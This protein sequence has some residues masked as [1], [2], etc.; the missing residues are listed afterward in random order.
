MNLSALPDVMFCDTDT[1]KIETAVIVTHEELTGKKLYPGDPVRLFLEGLAKVVVMQRV[2]I[3]TTAKQNL[4]AF[5][6]GEKLDHLGVLT[7]AVRLGQ[8]GAKTILRFSR[9]IPD[10]T[11][12]LIPVGT[13]VGPDEK[14]LFKTTEAGQISPG[15]TAVNVPA[16]CLTPGRIGDGF[17]PGQ[18]NVLIDAVT[19]VELSVENL[20]R[21]AGGADIEVD[22]RFR[23]R[24]QLSVERASTAGTAGGY[25]YW[26]M[27]AHQDIA[28]VSVISPEPGIVEVFVLMA[29]GALPDAVILELVQKTLAPDDV[30]PLTD[31]CC[32][33]SPEPVSGNI[34]IIW[35][36]SRSES[37]LASSVQKAVSNAVDEYVAWQ[38]AALGRDF[39]PTELIFRVKNAGASR[40][41]VTAPVHIHLELWQVARIGQVNVVYGGLEA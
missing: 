32:V 26:A 13:R 10:E 12:V 21:T 37:S 14:L 25:R 24:I 28:D 41:D 33:K 1:A 34:E 23:E 22:D 6:A 31:T 16:I 18:I 15:E 27:T 9:K 29:G 2:I 40:V 39:N 35:F 19:G 3:D 7:G 4:L 20:T 36:L 30:I 38:T 8:V 17:L 11:D 5:A